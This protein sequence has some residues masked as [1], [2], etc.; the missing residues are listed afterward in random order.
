[1]ETQCLQICWFFYVQGLLQSPGQQEKIFQN[2]LPVKELMGRVQRLK[3]ATY[4]SLAAGC[5][6]DNISST[7]ACFAPKPG[8][9]LSWLMHTAKTFPSSGQNFSFHF[10]KSEIHKSSGKRPLHWWRELGLTVLSTN[11][12]RYFNDGVCCYAHTYNFC[13]WKFPLFQCSLYN[14]KSLFCLSHKQRNCFSLSC[15]HGKITFL[16]QDYR[17]SHTGLRA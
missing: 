4:P 1:M 7:C 3:K 11:P 12:T 10:L 2:G 5:S 8:S 15:M 6:K 16:R 17:V 9:H 13:W 14:D